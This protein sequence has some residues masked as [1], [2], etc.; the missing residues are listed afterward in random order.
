MARY[1]R[2]R[3][4]RKKNR[5]NIEARPFTSETWST[6]NN[7][8]Q[9][10]VVIVPPSNTEGV[11]KAGRFTINFDN[12]NGYTYYWALVYVPEGATTSGLFPNSTTILNPSNYVLA[13]GI[14]GS[15]S[16]NPRIY[17]KL[18]KNLKAND[19]IMLY[20]ATSTS[21]N[22]SN[23]QLQGLIRYAVAYN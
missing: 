2:K 3:T 16:A 17:C 12:N 7:F 8:R 13:T 15:S 20:L 9:S 23:S 4:Y 11:R 19:Q 22:A 18:F 14:L 21:N 6:E 5:Y 1:Y 10:Q